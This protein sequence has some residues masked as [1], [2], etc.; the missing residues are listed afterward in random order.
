MSSGEKSTFYFD[1]KNVFL[2][3]EIISLIG[4]AIYDKIKELDIDAIGG[5]EVGSIPLIAA[6]SY[7]YNEHNRKINGFFVRNEVKKHGTK[8]IIEGELTKGSHVVIIDDVATKG[9]SI[10]KAINA[11][12]AAECIP[13]LIVALV[14]RESGAS[15]LFAEKEI[16]F[17]PVFSISQFES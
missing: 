7:T 11:V 15:K 16:K 8:K 10:M 12:I 17:E 13:V 2:S 6:T 4:K 14:D 9:G 1:V 3:S 5:M